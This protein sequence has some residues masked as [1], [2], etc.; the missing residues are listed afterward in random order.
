[1]CL[2]ARFGLVNSKNIQNFT[3]Q[4]FDFTG[5][6]LDFT[7]QLLDFTGQLLGFTGQLL[8]FTGQLRDY[9]TVPRLRAV[10]PFLHSELNLLQF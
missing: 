5:Q 1:M 9:G 7:G 8:D 3:G 6:L 10:Y 2:S 4:L